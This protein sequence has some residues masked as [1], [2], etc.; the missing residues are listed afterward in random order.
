MPSSAR[1]C[2]SPSAPIPPSFIPSYPSPSQLICMP[3]VYSNPMSSPAQ[4]CPTTNPLQVRSLHGMAASIQTQERQSLELPSEHIEFLPPGLNY[5]N[6][7]LAF[8]VTADDA[9]SAPL[10][11]AANQQPRILAARCHIC[12]TAS[13]VCLPD[14]PRNGMTVMTTSFSLSACIVHH[15]SFHVAIS[16]AHRG[17]RLREALDF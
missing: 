13:V 1:P 11:S 14:Y 2:P 8:R 17:S 5:L 10:L 12:L 9:R 15:E 6:Y 4:P 7:C 16:P 3:R